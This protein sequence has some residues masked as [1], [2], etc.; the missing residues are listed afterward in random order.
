MIKISCCLIGISLH[1]NEN[2]LTLIQ[3]L[4]AV[5]WK[6]PAVRLQLPVWLFARNVLIK[7]PGGS[8]EM[9]AYLKLPFVCNFPVKYPLSA[10]SK[11]LF[12]QDAIDSGWLLFSIVGA[13]VQEQAQHS[14]NHFVPVMLCMFKAPFSVLRAASS[15]AK[16]VVPTWGFRNS[17]IFMF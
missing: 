17:A 6:L 12:P 1:V 7:T 10:C 4:T 3:R 16:S 5:W 11:L 8:G 9:K 14:A 13:N 15:M 2:E